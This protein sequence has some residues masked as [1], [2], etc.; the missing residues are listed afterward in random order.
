MIELN[1]LTSLTANDSELAVFRLDFKF[2]GHMNTGERAR[3]FLRIFGQ[4]LVGQFTTRTLLGQR[5]QYALS[6]NQVR[7]PVVASFDLA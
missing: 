5:L 2:V 1:F 3:N 6:L 7:N 4:Y